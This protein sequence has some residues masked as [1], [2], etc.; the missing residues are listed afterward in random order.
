MIGADIPFDR[1]MAQ[2]IARI[3]ANVETV[4]DY[5]AAELVLS[6]ARRTPVD[7][8]RL[9]AGWHV[10]DLGPGRRRIANEVPYAVFVEY[11]TAN[12]APRAMAR[13]AMADWQRIVTR[14]VR[15]LR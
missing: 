9:R 6:I 1:Q 4:I 15:R 11:G 5:A 3:N 7:T 12:M 10:V 13:T 8:G 14:S 2:A